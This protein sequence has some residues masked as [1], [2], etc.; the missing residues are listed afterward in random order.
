[1]LADFEAMYEEMG[2]DNTHLKGERGGGVD[3]LGAVADP[4]ASKMVDMSSTHELVSQV[5]QEERGR[6][7]ATVGGVEFMEGSGLL[8][9]EEGELSS[10]SSGETCGV[11]R[12]VRACACLL[13][14]HVHI[15]VVRISFS[16]SLSF[17]QRTKKN[18]SEVAKFYKPNKK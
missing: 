4:R 14:L 5:S 2:G 12:K 6:E 10:D 17:L 18:E 7:V 16:L 13:L 11:R 9:V 3:A 15:H 8:D 1:M